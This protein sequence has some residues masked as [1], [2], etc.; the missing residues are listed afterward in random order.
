LQ[1]LFDI[2]ECHPIRVV[3]SWAFGNSPIKS[4]KLLNAGA[5]FGG[6][7]VKITPRHS[8]ISRIRLFK[9]RENATAHPKASRERGLG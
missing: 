9:P 4:E 6:D 3:K 5:L 8:P 1:S 2:P 7:G